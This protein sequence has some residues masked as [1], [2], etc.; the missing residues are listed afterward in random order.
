MNSGRVA[1][2]LSDPLTADRLTGEMSMAEK[3]DNDN[4]IFGVTC[5]NYHIS[6]F[7]RR[8]VCPESGDVIVRRMVRE[9]DKELDELVLTCKT[10]GCGKKIKVR[11]DCEGY[12]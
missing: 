12:K 4:P 11:V 1:E 6:Y 10:K 7:D 3:D 8:E 5:A 9:E 2:W